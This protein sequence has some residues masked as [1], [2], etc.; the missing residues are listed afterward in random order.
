M[1]NIAKT[2]IIEIDSV[3]VKSVAVNAS[4]VMFIVCVYFELLYAVFPYIPSIVKVEMI[5]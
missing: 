2:E 4:E 3:S 1:R 5:T